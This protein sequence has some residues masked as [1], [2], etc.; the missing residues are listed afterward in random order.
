ME[1]L[2]ILYGGQLLILVLAGMVGLFVSGRIPDFAGDL[3][4]DT[5]D[6]SD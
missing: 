3:A 6:E 1:I 5:T 2:A 4:V